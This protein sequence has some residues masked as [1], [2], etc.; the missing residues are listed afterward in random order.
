[1]N[2]K[3][4]SDNGIY[5]VHCESSIEELDGVWRAVSILSVME[6]LAYLSSFGTLIFPQPKTS[7]L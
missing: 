6:I 1:M 7:T 4:S 5:I 3:I 2:I